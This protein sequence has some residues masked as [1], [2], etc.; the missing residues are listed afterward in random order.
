MDGTKNKECEL[1][2]SIPRDDNACVWI[3]AF[4]TYYVAH[5][6]LHPV[7]MRSAEEL[8]QYQDTGSALPPKARAKPAPGAPTKRRRASTP[9]TSPAVQ[10]VPA[11][12]VNVVAMS[13]A[14]ATAAAMLRA[15]D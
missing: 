14:F 10:R 7:C 15:Q 2:G 5:G 4:L 8:Q 11:A 3:L 13:Q 1:C 6:R 9:A 12:G